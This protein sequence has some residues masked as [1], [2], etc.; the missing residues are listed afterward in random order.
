MMIFKNIFYLINFFFIKNKKFSRKNFKLCQKVIKTEGLFTFIKVSYFSVFLSFL[1]EKYENADI[2]Y[3]LSEIKDTSLIKLV[4]EKHRELIIS[5]ITFSKNIYFNKEFS[6]I[7]DI[8]LKFKF[9]FNS[10]TSKLLFESYLKFQIKNVSDYESFFQ[11]LNKLNYDF[12]V[13]SDSSDE[14]LNRRLFSTISY[15][16]LTE[17]FSYKISEFLIT[18]IDFRIKTIIDLFYS[19]VNLN[20]FSWFFYFYKLYDFD[21]IIFNSV[22]FIPLLKLNTKFKNYV[23]KEKLISVTK[24]Q[25]LLCQF[26]DK[27]YSFEKISLLNEKEIIL[28][29]DSLDSKDFVFKIFNKKG[30]V[31][32]KNFY[33]K[34]LHN[35]IINFH[36]LKMCSIFKEE[37]VNYIQNTIPLFSSLKVSENDF[38]DIDISNIST[39]FEQIN[40][41]KRN[42][43]ILDVY[44]NPSF[45]KKIKKNYQNILE[46]DTVFKINFKYTTI[47]DF[48]EKL[49]NIYKVKYFKNENLDLINF[50]P[51]LKNI[52]GK[53]L[54]E[55][56]IIEIPK[57]SYDLFHYGIKMNNCIF[58]YTKNCLIKNIIIIGIYKKDKIEYNL[59]LGLDFSNPNL[60]YFFN[61]KNLKLKILQFE[62]KHKLP[63][64]KKD[65][66]RIVTFL[67]KNNII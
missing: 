8:L 6:L 18:K 60:D 67:E 30:S 19:E 17:F 58:N 56:L 35:N 55:D 27:N 4:N 3:I 15:L 23:L 12:N 52:D 50:F 41:S 26:I 9:K 39:L 42:D 13:F 43:F 25:G 14:F 29:N 1:K 31:L 57:T 53:K 5:K 49:E 61:K 46:K 2:I 51:K 48:N 45:F 40:F 59:E 11:K 65:Y 20:S 7:M 44:E 24:K 64:P 34:L 10:K 66:F 33:K 36:F 63:I 28:M 16:K 37:D 38:S 32:L 47:I 54:G 21:K 62:K 22:E